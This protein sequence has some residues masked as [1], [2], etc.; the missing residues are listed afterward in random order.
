MP[1]PLLEPRRRLL[2]AA[3]AGALTALAGPALATGG[4]PAAVIERAKPSIV[5]VGTFQRLRNPAFQFSGTGFVIGNGNQVLTNA[6]VIP[7]VLDPTANEQFA[8]LTPGPSPT[9]RLARLARVNRAADLALVDIEGP[10]LP[11]L[12]LAEGPTVRE[13][14]D[15]VLIGF[16]IGA[17]LGIV[18]AAHRAFVAAVTPMAIPN[19]NA[20]TLDPRAVQA[21]RADPIEILQLDATAYPGNSGSPLLDLET[22]EVVGVINMVMVKGTRENA[23]SAPSGISYAIPVRYARELV[24]R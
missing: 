23:L 10:P 22:G 8:V 4:R 15:L 5:A 20:R 1:H 11:T 13:G 3:G 21:L 7:P 12:R 9:P 16:P 17:L 18:P 6:H 19:A 14:T 2:Q 24:A